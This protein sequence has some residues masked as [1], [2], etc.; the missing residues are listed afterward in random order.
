MERITLENDNLY[1]EIME[2]LRLLKHNQKLM[3][4]MINKNLNKLNETLK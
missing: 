3:K 4:K 2:Q 1:K